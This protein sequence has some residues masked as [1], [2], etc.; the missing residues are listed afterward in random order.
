MVTGLTVSHDVNTI[1]PLMIKVAFQQKQEV[2]NYIHA[3]FIVIE[4]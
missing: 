1:E 3:L 4:N 2:N